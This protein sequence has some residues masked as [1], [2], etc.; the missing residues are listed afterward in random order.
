MLATRLR[1][2]LTPFDWADLS[3]FPFVE[4]TIRIEEFLDESRYVVRAELPGVD[5]AKDLDLT[6]V[7]GA[8]RLTVR[9]TG[10]HREKGRSEFHYGS[11]HRTITLPAGTKDDTIRARYANGILEVTATIGEPV[12]LGVHIPVETGNGQVKSISKKS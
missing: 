10:D 1:G 8:L 6:Y 7:E 12:G 5:P 9:R 4:P 3:W 11:F 2:N